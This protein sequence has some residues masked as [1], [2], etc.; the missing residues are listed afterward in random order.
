MEDFDQLVSSTTPR[1]TT[2]QVAIYQN[3]VGLACPNCDDPFDDLII[4]K[5]PFNRL[6]QS[7]AM[8]ICVTTHE[9]NPV[10]FTHKQ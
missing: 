4:S 5:A 7:V 6:S 9:D 1:E 8:D 2:D 3:T 10:L